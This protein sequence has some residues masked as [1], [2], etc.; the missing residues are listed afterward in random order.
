MMD[1]KITHKGI[2]E[3]FKMDNLDC[4]AKAIKDKE[5]KVIMSQVIADFI[6]LSAENRYP[7]GSG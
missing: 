4:L 7:C 3:A 2:I 5:G 1:E 6:D